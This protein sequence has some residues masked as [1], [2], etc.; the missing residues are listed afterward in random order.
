MTPEEALVALLK[1]RKVT[2]VTAES[3]TGGM[4]AARIVNVPGASS[5]FPGGAVTYATEVK[6][7]LL[8]VRHESVERYTVVS[9]QVAREMALGAVARFGADFAVSITGFAGPGGGTE[10]IPVGRV[11][12]GCAYGEE[13]EAFEFTFDGGRDAVRQKG[14]DAALAC[15]YQFVLKKIDK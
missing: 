1:E 14:A 5:V 4:I 6:E 3:C 7:S 8:G 12:V 15:L 9:A 10:T 11:Y 2:A 13:A